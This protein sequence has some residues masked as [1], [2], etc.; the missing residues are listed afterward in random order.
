MLG[1]KHGSQLLA[2]NKHFKAASKGPARPLP[3]SSNRVSRSLQSDT[4]ATGTLFLSLKCVKLSFSR[5]VFLPPSFALV[6]S[7]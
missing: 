7:S 6:S 3:A 1:G 2:F 5:G 4:L